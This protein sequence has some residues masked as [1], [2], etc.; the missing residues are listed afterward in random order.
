M[1]SVAIE[2]VP[3]FLI[4]LSVAGLH[5]MLPSVFLLVALGI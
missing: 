4:K 1:P 5:L 3:L 2:I